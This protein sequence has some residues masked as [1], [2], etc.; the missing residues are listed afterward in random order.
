M[1]TTHGDAMN[2]ATYRRI[3]VAVLR[4]LIRHPRVERM[5][6]EDARKPSASLEYRIAVAEAIKEWRAITR[7]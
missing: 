5:H 4:D 3:K 6:L 1:S 2:E 7:S